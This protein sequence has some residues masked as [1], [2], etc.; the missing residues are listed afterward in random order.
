MATQNKL[1]DKVL[2]SK[3]LEFCIENGKIDISFVQRK[4]GVG[5]PKAVLSLDYLVELGYL[6]KD[7]NSGSYIMAMSS[8]ELNNSFK[9]EREKKDETVEESYNISFEDETISLLKNIKL[10]IKAID[11]G[12]KLGGLSV[13]A[14]QRQLKVGYPRAAKIIDKLASYGY[15][16]Q[17][18]ENGKRKMTI[19]V[20][21]FETL[22]N[23]LKTKMSEVFDGEN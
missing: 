14:L 4:F 20:E 7:E 2:S 6:K 8:E 3:L 19:T 5:Y 18:I 13:S 15:I 16:A 11:L 9:F 10:T 1:V 17:E 22:L 23:T 12:L 21:E